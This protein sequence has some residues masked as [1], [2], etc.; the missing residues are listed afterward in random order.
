[1]SAIDQNGLSWKNVVGVRTDG[2]PA[3]L[4]SRL[5]FVSLAKNKKPSIIGS[6]CV[7]TDKL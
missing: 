4:G 1:L 6:H 7:K 3:M 5:G 2:A